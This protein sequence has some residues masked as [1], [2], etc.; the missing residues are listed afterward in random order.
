MWNVVERRVDRSSRLD[1]ALTRLLRVQRE[2][3]ELDLIVLAT[4]EGLVVA[5][6]GPRADCEELAAYAP[7]VA[8]GRALAVDP[9]RLQGV[10]VHTFLAGRQELVLAIRGGV[11][12]D[13]TSA[14]AL[15]SMQG[16]TRILRG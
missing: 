13:V 8:R 4:T 12:A 7:L 15:S 3:G 5:Y 10:T 6:D 1:E 9:R 14:L 16:A 2:R 11:R